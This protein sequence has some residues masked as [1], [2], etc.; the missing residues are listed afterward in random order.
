MEV[1]RPGE[2]QQNKSTP[3]DQL[4]NNDIVL[5]EPEHRYA[6]KS[7]PEI[8]FTSVTSLTSKY[9]EPFNKLEVA[10]RLVETNVKY[11]GMTVDQLI[12]QWDESRDFGT[13]VHNN[14]ESYINSESFESISEVTHAIKWM[15][16]FKNLSEFI[17][18]PE[19]KI[20]SKEL[21]IAGTIDVLAHDTTNNTFIIVDWKTSKSISKVSFGG[22]MGI[23]PI[24]KHLMDCK[25]VHYSLQLS[26]YR[27]LLESYYDLKI[28]N[29]LIAHLNGNTCK[30]IIADYYKDVV[31]RI[32]NEDC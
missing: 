2:V 16:K 17:F 29:Q 24:T 28:T 18:Y 26:F 11:I 31:Q 27:Y 7:N 10:K 32:I 5:L 22:K 8:E 4:F 15:K 12:A 23:H 19:V 6:L 3:M 14:I 9:F 30:P 21:K 13:L 1:L 25:F 20:F